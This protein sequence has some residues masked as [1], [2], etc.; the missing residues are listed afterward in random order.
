M[1]YARKISGPIVDRIDIWIDVEQVEHKKL[2]SDNLAE[3]SA[4][5][6][7]R[8]EAARAIQQ[9]R[10][11]GTPLRSNSEIGAKEIKRFCG[12]ENT[13]AA[14]LDKAAGE[15]DLSARAYHRILKISRTIADLEGSLQ[16]KTAHLLEAL[17]YRPK[18]TNT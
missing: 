18:Q 8:V 7:K 9:T 13:A 4:D 15:L 17:Q 12:L 10:F 5:I 2:A 16:I 14:L 6:R 1:R 11:Q 3:S